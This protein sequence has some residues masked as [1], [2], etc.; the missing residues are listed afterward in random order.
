MV[1][2]ELFDYDELLKATDNFSPSRLIGKGS[3]GYIYLATFLKLL[4]AVKKPLS[5]FHGGL[6][7]DHN[8]NSSKIIENEVRVLSSLSQNSPPFIINLLG[9]SHDS[10]QNF[11]VMVMEFMPNGSLHDLLHL[12]KTPPSWPKRLQIVLQI[13]TAVSFLHRS[14][15]V[16]RDIKS[17]NV[18]FD[19]DWVAK[20]ADFGLAVAAVVSDHGAVVVPAGTIGYLDPCYTTSSKLSTK[21]DVFSFGVLVLEIISGRNAMEINKTPTDITEW[22]LPLIKKR[23]WNELYDKRVQS[24]DDDVARAVRQLAY[25]AARCVSLEEDC[26]P[27]MV[28]VVDGM[29]S[30]F[31]ERPIRRL[32]FPIW[33]SLLRNVMFVRIKG[34]NGKLAKRCRRIECEEEP[35]PPHIDD[36]LV[37]KGNKKLVLLR[38]LLLA[39]HDDDDHVDDSN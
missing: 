2:P 35:P 18:L 29:S 24:P 9:T 31:A 37:S 26:R 11:R 16:H 13:A 14:G 25:V 7:H 39:N 6:R 8:N 1:E 33:S 3:H 27:S 38:D 4:A 15:I 36:V 5:Y 12:V 10:V 19:S 20:L 23:Q 17:E 32:F 34:Q 21:N 30:C 22:A 28:D